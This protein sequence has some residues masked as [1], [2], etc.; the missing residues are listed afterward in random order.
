LWLAANIN[1]F[2]VPYLPPP[3]TATLLAKQENIVIR[4][5]VHG[6]VK[7]LRISTHFYNAPEQVDRLFGVLAKWSNDP[8]VFPVEQKRP[9]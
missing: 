4:G 6:D 7:A 1:V 9:A 3:Q 5:L 8:P 2:T